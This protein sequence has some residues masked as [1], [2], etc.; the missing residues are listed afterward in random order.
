MHNEPS[1]LFHRD[2]R[3]P[4]VILDSNDPKTWFLVDWD[5][6]TTSPT[7]AANHLDPTTHSPAVFKDGHGAE[8]DLW[9]VGRLI[10]DACKFAPEISET[11]ISI[12]KQ[13]V[14]GTITTSVHAHEHVRQSIP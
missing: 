2:I 11:M 14:Q 7:F 10:L 8:V 1:P 6:A 12:G 9:G 4:N 13:L 3:W 5:D